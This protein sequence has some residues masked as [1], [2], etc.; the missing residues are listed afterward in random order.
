MERLGTVVRT[1][2]RLAIA[3]LPGDEHPR[4]GTEAVDE[5]LSSIGRV[6]DIFGPVDRPY[7]AIKLDDDSN[8]PALLGAKVYAR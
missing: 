2:N 5:Q 6:V 7:V 4:M 3:R 1:A 8:L